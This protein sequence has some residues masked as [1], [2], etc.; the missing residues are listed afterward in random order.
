MINKHTC[1]AIRLY[2][3]LEKTS[4]IAAGR[5]ASKA[6]VVSYR[7]LRADTNIGAPLTIFVTQESTNLLKHIVE[8]RIDTTVRYQC[9]HM[10]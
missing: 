4:I 2:D 6:V 3:T 8:S 5:A 10:H 1:V 9:E 7:F